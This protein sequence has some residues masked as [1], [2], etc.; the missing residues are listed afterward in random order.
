MQV[1]VYVAFIA[2]LNLCIGAALAYLLPP[3][4]QDKS[5]EG[6][7][8]SRD[9]RH[10]EIEHDRQAASDIEENAEGRA[11]SETDFEFRSTHDVA[12]VIDPLETWS[13]YSGQLRDIRQ[14]AQYCRTSQDKNLGRQVA[15]QLQNSIENWYAEL[16]RMLDDPD[17]ASSA[18]F[19]I[20]SLEMFSSQVETSLSNIKAIDW[21]LKFEETLAQIENEI[22]L[23]HEQ[24]RTV[25]P[26]PGRARAASV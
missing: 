20:A 6:D 11:E 2:I 14:R 7:G 13:A 12:D 16:Q 21:S 15:S 9:G 4:R 24:Q 25:V 19:D 8:L 23:L 22:T 10:D 1:V 3:L 26:S 5:I 18:G 17:E